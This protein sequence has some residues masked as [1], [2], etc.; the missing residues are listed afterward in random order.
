MGVVLM[1]NP[2]Q[3]VAEAIKLAQDLAQTAVTFGSRVAWL[4]EQALQI[5]ELSPYR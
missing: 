2:Q 3:T 4:D 1:D 5:A